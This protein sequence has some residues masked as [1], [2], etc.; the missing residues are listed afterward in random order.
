MNDIQYVGKHMITYD[1][2]R[3]AHASWEL[4][5]CTYGNG[6]IYFDECSLPYHEG[7]VAVIPPNVP[8]S[9]RSEG[10]ITNIHLNISNPTLVLRTPELIADDSNRFL[11]NAFTAAFYH[12]CGDMEQRQALLSS[13]GNLIICYLAAYREASR[14]SEIVERI[15]NCIIQ[16]YPDCDFALDA[17]LQS[18]PFNYDYLRKLF[19][20]ELGITPH[21]FLNDLRLETAAES[22]CLAGADGLNIT[23]VA[24]ECGFRE[25]LYF[26]RMFK[27][28]YGVAPSR[29]HGS[30]PRA[31]DSDSMKIRLGDEVS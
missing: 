22:I 30:A 11:L 2:S 31:G 1:V 16:N 24:R 14:H 12:Y 18:L 7:T 6:T 15:E 20:K 5:Y 19:K 23:E 10:G 9:N 25:P 28:K 3:H 17:Y 27:K 21:Q 8:H 26:S 29:Y 4:I 13:Y